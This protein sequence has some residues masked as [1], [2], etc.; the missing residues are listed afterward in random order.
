MATVRIRVK[1]GRRAF[2]EG[3]ELKHDWQTVNETEKI[4]RLRDHWGDIEQEDYTPPPP[5]AGSGSDHILDNTLPSEG[6]ARA[7]SRRLPQ[8][9]RNP[10]ESAS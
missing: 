8:R 9:P 6:G 3:K 5:P 4:I 7:G 2:N 1:E 10:D